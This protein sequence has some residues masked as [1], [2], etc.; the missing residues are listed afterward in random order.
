M[1]TRRAA[2]GC[3]LLAAVVAATPA[4]ATAQNN[5]LPNRQPSL[6]LVEL[7]ADRG[8]HC[9]LLRPWQAASLRMQARDQLATFDEAGRA[10][11]AAEIDARRP[12][13]LCDDALLKTWI[14]AAGPNF[15]REHLPELLAGYRAFARQITPPAPF[16]AAT[17]RTDYADALT[18]IEDKLAALESAG[19]QP[20]GRMSWPAL[21]ERQAGFAAQL[22]AAISGIGEAGRFS[23][24]QAA[25]IAEDVGRIG[26]LWLQD[27]P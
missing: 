27:A 7:I 15:D 23:A 3:L 13:M 4:S 20:P 10:A 5:G 1:N 17:G 22:A 11:I 24:E 16:Q 18:R 26:E 2:I 25:Q 21:A 19:V 8:L 12:K 9:S 6:I 14:E